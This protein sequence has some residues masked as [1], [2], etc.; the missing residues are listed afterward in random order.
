[1]QQL[2]RTRIRL[3]ADLKAVTA[4]EYAMIASLIAVAFVVGAGSLG[5]HL[6][7]VFAAISAAL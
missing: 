6:S 3:R 5:G 4:L 1:M 7:S 2:H